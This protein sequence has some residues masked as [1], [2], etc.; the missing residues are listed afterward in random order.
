MAGDQWDI[1][2]VR[3][4]VSKIRTHL[5]EQ[6][7]P[8]GERMKYVEEAL[9]P[10]PINW[11]GL[12]LEMMN[13]GY[14][15]GVDVQAK[16]IARAKNDRMWSLMGLALLLV[17]IILVFVK[18]KMNPEQAVETSLLT[19]IGAAALLV[20]LPGFLELQGAIKPNDFVHSLKFK[21]AGAVAIFILTF[22]LIRM[23]ITM[24]H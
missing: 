10:L 4:E 1:D 9:S 3:L 8:P 21:G 23:A 2:R 14:T 12:A 17:G 19:A 6:P 24:I 7:P 16:E 11:Q 22:I 5:T 15:F 18:P 13:L 20:N